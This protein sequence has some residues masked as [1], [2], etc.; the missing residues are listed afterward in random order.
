MAV[1]DAGVDLGV[2]VTSPRGLVVLLVRYQRGPQLGGGGGHLVMGV[3]GKWSP[4]KG[5]VRQ[6]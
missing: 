2:D 1:S 3:S 6:T 5:R 4:T